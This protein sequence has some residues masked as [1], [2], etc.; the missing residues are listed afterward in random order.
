MMDQLPP[1]LLAA[2]EANRDKPDQTLK[3]MIDW[4]MT[5]ADQRKIVRDLDARGAARSSL[6]AS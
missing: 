5:E 2:L 4:F 3:N 1:N 6:T